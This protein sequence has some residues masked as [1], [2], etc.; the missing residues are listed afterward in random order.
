MYPLVVD[1]PLLRTLHLVNVTIPSISITTATNAL[2]SLYLEL[3]SLTTLVINSNQ[4]SLPISHLQIPNIR[5]FEL[6]NAKI[7]LGE[8]PTTTGGEGGEGG[9]IELESN[10]LVDFLLVN[11]TNA[12]RVRLVGEERR[13]KNVKIVGNKE[14]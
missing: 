1:P 10:D 9:W 13:L 4:L 11:C 14:L 8:M 12:K 5:K 3:P 2:T 7:L 6:S